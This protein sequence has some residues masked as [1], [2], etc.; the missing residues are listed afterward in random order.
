M[1][2]E[3][4]E[5]EEEGMEEEERSAV[6]DDG[7]RAGGGSGEIAVTGGEGEV[8]RLRLGAIVLGVKA[9]FFSKK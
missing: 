8:M 6:F 7:R 1:V 3:E 5:E 2:K 9:F 4:E